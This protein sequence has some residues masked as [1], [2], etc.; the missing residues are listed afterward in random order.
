[1]THTS[2]KA[3]MLTPTT[4]QA[5]LEELRLLRNEITLLLPHEDLE[6]YAHPER[7][8]RS[9]ENARKHYPLRSV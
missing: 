6:E 9:L 5:I 1:M 7:L 3:T 2:A 4:A 8:K